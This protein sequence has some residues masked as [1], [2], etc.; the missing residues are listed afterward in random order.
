M[1]LPTSVADPSSH[2]LDGH[3]C[4]F[5]LLVPTATHS[6]ASLAMQT[7]YILTDLAVITHTL[8]SG[9]VTHGVAMT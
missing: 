5:I 8:A 1:F 6:T 4:C 3:V 7:W 9:V 2:K